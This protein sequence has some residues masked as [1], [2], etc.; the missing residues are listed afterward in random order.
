MKIILQ[1]YHIQMIIEK[2]ILYGVYC[3]REGIYL[4]SLPAMYYQELG[5]K[6][7]SYLWLILPSQHKI[8]E[9]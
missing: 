8:L 3:N 7:S 5:E 9:F 4:V 6:G 1:R 2:F